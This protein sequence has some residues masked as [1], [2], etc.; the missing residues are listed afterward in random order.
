MAELAGRPGTRFG[1]QA[2]GSTAAGQATALRAGLLFGCAAAVGAAAWLGNPQASLEADVE[3]AHLL[4]GM[5]LIKAAIC[6]LAIGALLWRF[7]RPMSRRLAAAY[8][9]GAWLMAGASTLIW[10]L[11]F[12][13]AAAFAFHGGEFTLLI[14][15]W[16]DRGGLLRQD[17]SAR[18]G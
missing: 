13:P 15:A 17:R 2:S 8:L 11:T 18:T 9:L 6:G 7:G 1:R 3:L 16:R 4:R 12:I 10:Q 14:A 5:A